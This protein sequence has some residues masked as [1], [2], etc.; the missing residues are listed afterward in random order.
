MDLGAAARRNVGASERGVGLEEHLAAELAANWCR[1]GR[2]AR[3][4]AASELLEVIHAAQSG[5][6]W[7][8]EWINSPAWEIWHYLVGE[9]ERAE[10]HRQTILGRI[11][12]EAGAPTYDETD[13]Y[14]RAWDAHR[15]VSGVA[16]ECG[17]SWATA[18][19]WIRCALAGTRPRPRGRPRRELSFAGAL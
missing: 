14:L 3:A 17:V 10:Q 5:H 8:I 15:S 16:R 4:V 7:A 12:A 13:R 19:H 2:N 11:L 1:A 6:A 18:R 9:G